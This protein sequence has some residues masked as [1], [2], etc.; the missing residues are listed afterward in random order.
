MKINEY[1]LPIKIVYESGATI[2]LT[3]GEW[4]ELKEY[5]ISQRERYIGRE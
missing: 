1:E 4:N 2:E 5:I 3:Q